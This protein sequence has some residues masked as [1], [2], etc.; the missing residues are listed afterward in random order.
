[1]NSE[2]I[3]KIREN[4]P[5]TSKVCYLNN[6][7]NGPLPKV[8]YEAM[9]K[10]ADK[11]YYEGRYLPFIKELY[12]EMDKTRTLLAEIL[13]ASYREVA[14]TQSTTEALNIVFWGLNWQRGDE[15]I[16]TNVDH[17]S[18]LAPLAQLKARLGIAVKYLGVDY[19][20][21]M[22]KIYFWKN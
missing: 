3:K 1:M 9:K 5:T 7:T 22:M 11:E 16:T 6:G 19:G 20:E 13:G 18:V 17:T 21:N 10:E 2:K 4:M 12:E 8:A 15:V 14:L